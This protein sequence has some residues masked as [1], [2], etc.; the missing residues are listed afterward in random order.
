M[1]HDILPALRKALPDIKLHVFGDIPDDARRSL[2]T[3]GLELHGR[4]EDL[5]PWMDSCL[6]SLAPLRF[7]AGVKGKINMAMSYGMPVIATTTAVEGM[8]LRDGSDVLVADTPA[9]CVIAVL[10]LQRDAAL[11]QRLSAGGM[12]NVL[13]YFSPAAADATLRRILH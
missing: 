13:R 7:G 2:A 9:A 5:T 8:Q 6:A 4:V 12:E 10:Q 1:A 3:P 11:W